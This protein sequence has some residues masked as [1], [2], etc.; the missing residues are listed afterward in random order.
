M[1]RGLPYSLA[2]HLL[3]LVLVLVFGN[4]V[5]HQPFE[6]PRTIRIRTVTLP[7]PQVQPQTQPPVETEPAPARQQDIVR[8]PKEVPDARPVEPEPQKK[9]EPEPVKPPPREPEPE[10]VPDEAP[11]ET[12]PAMP[13]VSGPSVSQT[14]VDFPFANYLLRVQGQIA[15]SWNPRQA[16]FRDNSVVSCTVHFVIARSGA[17]SQVTLSSSS[18]IGVF[19]REALRVIQSARFPQLPLNYTYS[20]LGVSVVF[21]LEPEF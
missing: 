19:D 13:V 11:A 15:R 10:A 7:Q 6:P 9:P 21:N 2:V 14:D 17:V 16:G 4:R 8:P 5:T 18:G 3:T 1:S 12:A 20:S